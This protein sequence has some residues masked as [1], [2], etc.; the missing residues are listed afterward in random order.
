M[1]EN[2]GMSLEELLIKHTELS[3]PLSEEY[4]AQRC[5]EVFGDSEEFAACMKQR[6]AGAIKQV[7]KEI[8]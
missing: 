5:R 8:A 2:P 3:Q 4:V 1:K 6:L 7:V